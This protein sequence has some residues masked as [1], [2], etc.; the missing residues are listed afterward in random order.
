MENKTKR[1]A[2][3]KKKKNWVVAFQS[4]YVIEPITTKTKK[5]YS[6]NS[7][8]KTKP[9]THTLLAE[10]HELG[11]ISPSLLLYVAPQFCWTFRLGPNNRYALTTITKFQK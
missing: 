9:R 11:Y 1:I 4:R 6:R 10:Q 5:I 3:K 7:D 2:K 8:L